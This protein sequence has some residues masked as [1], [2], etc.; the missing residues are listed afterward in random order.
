L[1]EFTNDAV[2]PVIELWNK[3]NPAQ[4]RKMTIDKLCDAVIKAIWKGPMDPDQI[5]EATGTAES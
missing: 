2:K 5:R 4:K 3:T 1:E